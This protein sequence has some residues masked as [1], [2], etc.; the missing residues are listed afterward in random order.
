MLRELG[1]VPKDVSLDAQGAERLLTAE[2]RQEWAYRLLVEVDELGP[3]R[4]RRIRRQLA[5]LVGAA[6]V[7]RID[8]LPPDRSGVRRRPGR[9]VQQQGRVA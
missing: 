6:T 7:Q 5:G 1:N 3:I 8:E 2:Y 9:A 4:R